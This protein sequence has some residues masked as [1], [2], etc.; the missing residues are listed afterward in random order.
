MKNKLQVT[1]AQ[2]SYEGLK[3]INQDFHGI[4]IPNDY[5][6]KYKGI[7]IALA[8]GISSSD[9]SDIASNITVNSFL[10]D[11]YC[12]SQT[13]S[14]KKSVTRILS[15]TNSW[16]YSQTKKNIDSINK[17]KGYI[18]TF[19]SII[20]KSTTAHIFHLG[21]SRIYRIRNKKIEQLT[22]DHRVWVSSN[23]SYLSR[24]M[25]MDSKLSIDYDTVAIEKD[26][27]F[28]LS[29]DG[30]Y[31][32]IEDD[33]LIKNLE[34]YKGDYDAL[35]KL[36]V[37]TALENGSDDN[38]TIQ[39]VR[40]DNI[41]NKELKD[42]DQEL[43]NKPLPPILEARESFDGYTIIR[44]L[45]STPRS[46]VYLAY[47]EES[48]RNVVLKIP[49][50]E[51]QEDKAYLEKFLLEDWIAKK[52]NNPH[53]VKSYIATR[54][55]NYLYN[56]TEFIQG[57][58]LTQWIKDNP[59]P[60]LQEVR[61]IVEQI[62]KGIYAFHKLE[63]LHQDLR[64]EN[65]LIDESG[66]IKIIDFGS[67][68]IEGLADIDTLTEQYNL[69]GTALYS[70][71]EYFLGYLGTNRS[72]I[73]SLAVITYQML[74]GKF[75]YGTNIAKC[76]TAKQQRKLKYKTLYEGETS[77]IPLWVNETLKKALALN[78]NDRYGEVSEF[79]YDLKNPNKKFLRKKR[80]A[81]I[82]RNPLVFWQVSTL[83][84]AVV[85]MIQF[86]NN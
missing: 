25:G 76:T 1:T 80:P 85:V 22:Q 31:E 62:A 49:S 77:K 17:D 59:K 58:T 81:L 20:L 41:P 64:P 82:E 44:T 5:L 53:V 71:P 65:I 73:F 75:P 24:A 13:W 72:D 37:N 23:K 30:V 3:D 50:I 51:L 60:K 52:I 2:Y 79:I 29:T 32:F 47:D 10:E 63:M 55:Q 21:D 45:N 9:V 28:I 6:L 15:A 56:V 4:T 16:L 54:K 70:A 86:L 43:E 35:G 27:I 74:S 38:L 8:D 11:Y 42:I 66:S 48:K 40:V 78:P 69:Q 34:K 18:C 26:D 68:K 67:T 83:I 14:V 33:F 12:T 46:Y 57:Q 7:S 84:L 36:I 39:I 19:S 61:Q